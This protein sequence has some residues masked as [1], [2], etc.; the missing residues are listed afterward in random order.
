MLT[1]VLQK[2]T[3]AVL[4]LCALTPE[5]HTTVRVNRD[6]TEMDWIAK[7][8]HLHIIIMIDFRIK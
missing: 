1:S 8:N 6:I 5:D 2:N 7:V 4:M 3:L